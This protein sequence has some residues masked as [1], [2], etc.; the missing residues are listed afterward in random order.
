MSDTRECLDTSCNVS[1]PLPT[2]A[3]H[4]RAFCSDR[5]RNRTKKRR[6]RLA[7][8]KDWP[9]DPMLADRLKYLLS[10]EENLETRKAVPVHREIGLV[11]RPGFVV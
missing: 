3:G 7:S 10:V 9:V 8:K 5:C 6:W 2:G 11:S 1:F 4:A